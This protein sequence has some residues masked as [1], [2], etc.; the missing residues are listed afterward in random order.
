MTH[1]KKTHS[2]ITLVVRRKK[3]GR[4]ERFVHLGTGNYNDATAKK[5][6]TDLG[7]ITSDEK[8]FGIDATNFFNYLSVFT[9]K[10]RNTIIYQWDHL[11]FVKILLH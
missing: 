9:E 3:N 2:K 4:I 11:I 8:K 6:Y 10:N 1:L 5:I 7:L